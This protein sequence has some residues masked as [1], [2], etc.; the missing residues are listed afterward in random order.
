[1]FVDPDSTAAGQRILSF[2]VSSGSGLGPIDIYGQV[3]RDAALSLPWAGV[4]ITQNVMA[5]GTQDGITYQ[6]MPWQVPI[7]TIT[8]QGITGDAVLSAIEIDAVPEQ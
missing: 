2:Q 4:A 8:V 1:M 3:G 6:I 7:L 5:P